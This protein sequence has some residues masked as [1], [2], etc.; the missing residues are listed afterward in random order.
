MYNL[1]YAELVKLKRAKIW[2]LFLV[3]AILPA[4]LNI[5]IVLTFEMPTDVH[6]LDDLFLSNLQLLDQP[7]M[8]IMLS[9]LAGHLFGREY[10]E[11][12]INTLFTYPF[13][14]LQVFFSKLIVLFLLLVVF[15][16]AA[17]LSVLSTAWTF[18]ADAM[19]LSLLMR[20]FGIFL[21]SA[22][23]NFALVPIYALVTMILKNVVS[24][25]LVGIAM[26]ISNGFL[27]Y[28][29]IAA[30]SPLSLPMLLKV[31]LLGIHDAYPKPL[32]NPMYAVAGLVVVFVVSFLGNI[33]YL[34]KSDVH[35]GS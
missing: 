6:D 2:W 7:M 12:T 30:W 10:S 14:R 28:S 9:L 29:P 11:R 21:L 34:K 32:D 4:Q 1:T 18:D 20:Y 26:M 8:Q 23:A 24:S 25:V 16:V 31:S 15:F 27:M 13:S 22:V 3:A 17:Y 35:S 19:T 33:I 5:L